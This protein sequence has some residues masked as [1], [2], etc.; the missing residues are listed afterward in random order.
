MWHCREKKI[1]GAISGLASGR[2]DINRLLADQGEE[3][4]LEGPHQL[5]DIG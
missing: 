5:Q 3:V 1:S 2:K 4:Y